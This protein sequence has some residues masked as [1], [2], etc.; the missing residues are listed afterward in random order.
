[1][2]LDFAKYAYNKTVDRENYALVKG[3]LTNESSKAELERYILEQR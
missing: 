3:A 1:M 2:R